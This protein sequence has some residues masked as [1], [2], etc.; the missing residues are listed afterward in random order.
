MKEKLAGWKSNM[1]SHAGRLVLIKSVLMTMPVYYMSLEMLPRGVIKDINKL[2]AKFFWGKTNQTRY[3]SLI[4]WK[5]VC[6]PVEKGGLGVKHL[7]SFGEALFMKIVWALMADEDKPWVQMCKAKYYPKVGYLRARYS[8]GGSKMWRQVLS[9]RELF[10]EQVEWRI[11][12]GCRA[13]ALSQPWFQGWMVQEEATA[14]DRGLKVKDLMDE[15]TGQ[16]NLQE[17]LRLYQPNQIQSILTC[18]NRPVQ[19]EGAKDKLIW[20][21][22]KDGKYAAKEGYKAHTHMQPDTMGDYNSLWEGIWKWK[23]ITPKIKIFFWRLLNKSLP[24]TVHLHSRFPH[25]SPMCQRCQEENEYEMHSLFFCNTSR[26]VW[27]G[28]PLGI[29]V[30]ELPQDIKEAIKH[31]TQTLDGYGVQ[32]FANTIWEIW[33]ERNKA[34]IEHATFQPQ[35]VLQRVNIAIRPDVNTQLGLRENAGIIG[36]KYEFYKEGWQVIIDASW[37]NKGRAGCAYILYNGGQMHS[38][39]VQNF[40]LNDSFMAESMALLEAI[41]HVYQYV[42]LHPLQKVQFFSDCLNLVQAVNQVDLTD[43]PSWRAHEIVNN[44]IRLM[45]DRQP[46]ATLHHVRR[47]AVEQAHRLANSAR[48][49]GLDFRGQPNVIMQQQEGIRDTMDVSFFQ[50]VQEAPP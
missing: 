32:L 5:N 48:R 29:R 38:L 35:G 6:K 15:Q 26:Q 14:H 20:L 10:K 2:M 13:Y 28:S 18:N 37:D 12:N 8:A 17:L 36:E 43:L 16:W 1:L 42:G 40:E 44:I 49:R 50:Q 7:Q 46:G 34:V 45:E 27:F 41:E 24:M 22:T 25:F 19:D 21:A 33:K 30:H 4:A 23:R 31:I 9:K 39:G 3:L 11:G 47:E